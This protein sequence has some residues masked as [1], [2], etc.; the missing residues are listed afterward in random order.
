M[1]KDSTDEVSSLESEIKEIQLRLEKIIENGAESTEAIKNLAYVIEAL[2]E[3]KDK[4]D[5]EDKS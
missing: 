2:S 3:I 5:T 1:A 4:A